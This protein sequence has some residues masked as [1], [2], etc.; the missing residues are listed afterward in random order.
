MT[1]EVGRAHSQVSPVFPILLALTIGIVG[2]AVLIFALP[3]VRESW[4]GIIAATL[5]AYALLRSAL[6]AIQVVRRPLPKLDMPRGPIK[7]VRFWP[8]ETRVDLLIG[9]QRVLLQPTR[10]G[11]AVYPLAVRLEE[12]LQEP[13]S[14]N[15]KPAWAAS[16]SIVWMWLLIF[17][18]GALLFLLPGVLPQLSFL[19]REP[20]EPGF[21]L[22]ASELRSGCDGAKF[23]AID[24]ARSARIRSELIREACCDAAIRGGS[25]TVSL[26][27]ATD[28]PRLVAIQQGGEVLADAHEQ[29]TSR[30]ELT[31][32]LIGLATLLL[33]F[34]A[35]LVW[36]GP[37]RRF[38]QEPSQ[39][40][41][42]E[43]RDSGAQVAGAIATQ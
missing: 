29:R 18:V 38:R 3:L 33:E 31:V 1:E 13:T 32:A 25:A 9:G 10:H 11:Q 16:P 7:E 21:I 28:P 40:L 22:P 30:A 27:Y 12:Q 34:L 41:A 6:T 4:A 24:L 14:V 19:A 23:V 37:W 15:G 26:D 8:G 42:R 20:P 39:D 2:V 17:R 5:G 43:I 36:F 35:L